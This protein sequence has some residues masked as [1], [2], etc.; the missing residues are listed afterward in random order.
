[1]HIA[2]LTV[3]LQKMNDKPKKERIMNQTTDE[4]QNIASSN[5]GVFPIPPFS[6]TEY[7]IMPIGVL[8]AT[9]WMQQVLNTSNE[10]TSEIVGKFNSNT[11]SME[12]VDPSN[13]K[14]LL[15][16]IGYF[17]IQQSDYYSYICVGG[18]GAS[19]VDVAIF[20]DQSGAGKQYQGFNGESFT[21]E[22]A[23]QINGHYWYRLKVSLSQP[24]PS[25]AA[26]SMTFYAKTYRAERGE[27]KPFTLW[28]YREA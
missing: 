3:Q 12:S 25:D 1:M 21:D 19:E 27:A 24:F 7:P 5:A 16:V 8:T 4:Y 9:Q 11:Q 6:L 28:G 18:P 10:P 26:N 13:T 22:P 17:P 2:F 23:T 20:P 15:S 14:E